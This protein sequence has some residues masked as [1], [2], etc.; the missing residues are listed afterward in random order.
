MNPFDPREN[1]SKLMKK[2]YFKHKSAFAKS[3]PVAMSR[4][5]MSTPVPAPTA[6]KSGE[7]GLVICDADNCERYALQPPRGTRFVVACC[8]RHFPVEVREHY[9]EEIMELF[10][11]S[12]KTLC[13]CCPRGYSE[14]MSFGAL[15][16]VPLQCCKTFV[17]VAC[18]DAVH[19]Q[20]CPFC[21]FNM[22]PTPTELFFHSQYLMHNPPCLRVDTT[23][24]PKEVI[25]QLDRILGFVNEIYLQI[26][27]EEYRVR[28][29]AKKVGFT[30]DLMK[31]IHTYHNYLRKIQER[32]TVYAQKHAL[33]IMIL[34]PFDG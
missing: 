34:E 13:P 3:S 12:A 20:C 7:K 8:V 14:I 4:T 5:A 11:H 18:A 1:I 10:E 22:T 31:T 25:K 28:E 27:Y 32:Y 30:A 21:D 16:M 6:Y 26:K 2:S 9:C 17:C 15:G 23:K 29:S 19:G 33:Q 24:C